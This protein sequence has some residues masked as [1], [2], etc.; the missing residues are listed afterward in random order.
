MILA[1]TVCYGVAINVAAPV[2]QEYG[3]LP[4]MARMLALATVWIAPLGVIAAPDS[5]LEWGPLIA[6]IV[7]G[8]VG[9]GLA[10]VIFGNLVG[11]VGSTR[12]SFITY[13]IPVVAIVLGVVFRDD[14]VAPLALLGVALVIV[15][16]ILASR[17]ET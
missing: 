5:S 4:V 2:Q 12:A 17:R 1:A 10:F 6:T 13:M 15:G 3:S 16:A 8:V 7:V 9:T 11:R 14:E